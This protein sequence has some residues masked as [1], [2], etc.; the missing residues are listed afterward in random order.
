MALLDYKK[1][2][3]IKMAN[4]TATKFDLLGTVTKSTDGKS[5]TILCTASSSEPDLGQ[6]IM[7]RNALEQMRDSFP[8]MTIFLN[9]KYTVPED[10]VGSV[11]SAK[12]V[13]RDGHDDLDLEITVDESNPRAAS[14]LT[15]IRAGTR[16]G[17]SIGVLVESSHQVKDSAGNRYLQID[18]V[19]VLEASIVGIPA[20]R[21]SWVQ[22]A[23]KAASANFYSIPASATNANASPPEDASELELAKYAIR[24]YA[25]AFDVVEKQLEQRDEMITALLVE[26]NKILDSPQGRKINPEVEA[27]LSAIGDRYGWLDENVKALMARGGATWER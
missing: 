10:V 3:L 20:N 2:R 19:K 14:V 22:S 11:K 24:A 18:S 6:D 25:A 16:L 26:C 9:H 23:L 27:G 8:S 13:S 17:V 21:R 15:Q 5:P 1:M 12:L 4:A 7:S